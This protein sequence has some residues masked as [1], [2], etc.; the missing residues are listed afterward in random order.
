MGTWLRSSIGAET[1]MLVLGAR[2]REG[3]EEGRGGRRAPCCHVQTYPHAPRAAC[4]PVPRTAR[5]VSGRAGRGAGRATAARLSPGSPTP[6]VRF[7]AASCHIDARLTSDSRG[8]RDGRALATAPTAAQRRE[9]LR[10][11]R[12]EDL[13]VRAVGGVCFGA[14]GR[15]PLRRRVWPRVRAPLMTLLKRYCRRHRLGRRRGVPAAPPA[16]P[17]ASALAGEAPETGNYRT[18]G[19]GGGG[20]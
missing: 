1:H 19:V 17:F 2:G 20:S 8:D 13:R 14:I 10:F 6:N 16:R 3:D 9:G 4:R 15:A 12:S 11:V 7:V 5:D 18:L